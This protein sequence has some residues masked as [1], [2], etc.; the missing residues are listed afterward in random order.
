[1]PHDAKSILTEARALIADPEHWTQESLA[2]QDTG[3]ET[4]PTSEF[5]YAWCA[6]GAL[7]RVS[8]DDDDNTPRVSAADMLADAASQILNGR[9]CVTKGNPIV[10]LNDDEHGV[11]DTPEETHAAVIRAFDLAISAA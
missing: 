6:L 4:T 8:D 2:I 5:A 11:F 10:Q 1:M 3:A 9:N 7:Q